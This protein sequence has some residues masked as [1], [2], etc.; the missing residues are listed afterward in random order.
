MVFTPEERRIRN[1]TQR[2]IE[3]SPQVPARDQMKD[4]ERQYARA[5]G[6]NLRQYVRIGS[7]LYYSEFLPVN[8]PLPKD[9][10]V[11]T[12]SD[13]NITGNLDVSGTAALGGNADFNGDLD[14]D[15]STNL[16]NT[17]ID[18]TLVVDG[19]NISLDSTATLNIDNSNT[20]NGVTIA[21]ATSGVPISIGHSTSETT[22]NDNLVLTG[23]ADFN[24]D[25]DV[26]GATTLDVT[27]VAGAF[28]TVGA[29]QPAG[30]TRHGALV[31]DEDTAHITV[32][33]DSF[34]ADT[35]HN[36]AQ[37][38]VKGNKTD[39]T[40]PSAAVA[41]GR[42]SSFFINTRQ[43]P[44]D[45]WEALSSN[46]AGSI[47]F[48][49]GD[50]IVHTASDRNLKKDISTI[51]GALD[52]VNA[53]RGVRFKWKEEHERFKSGHPKH[54]ALHYGFI[55][56]EVEEIAPELVSGGKTTV[57]DVD[58]GESKEIDTPKVIQDANEFSAILVEAIKELSAEVDKLKE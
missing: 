45:T 37:Y 7:Q 31:A 40:S 5:K 22:V 30:F 34:Q 56:Q 47:Y 11:T 44:N 8:E 24:G 46:T 38:G 54:Q 28:N 2:R 6:E 43:H 23:N 12:L 36:F 33:V 25:L 29:L 35:A 21:T 53:L 26:D 14:V 55:A 10:K 18:G 20:S 57:K 1:L 13:V 49:N 27:D 3:F 42:S 19:S 51:S 17:D 39:G 50:T 41:G 52:K 9:A 32:A 48:D 58:T 16:D 4:G 15:G